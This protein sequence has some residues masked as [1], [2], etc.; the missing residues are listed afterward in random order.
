MTLAEKFLIRLNKLGFCKQTFEIHKELVEK[1]NE[2]R[3]NYD[4]IKK[5][6]ENGK[7]R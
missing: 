3:K 6:K 7:S 1:L 4:L 5:E 2:D